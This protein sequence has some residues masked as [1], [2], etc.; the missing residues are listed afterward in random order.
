[1]T[2][3]ERA[4][5]AEP[6]VSLRDVVL[7]WGGKPMLGG[8][9]FSVE[10]GDRLAVVGPNGAGKSTLLFTMLGM[11]PPVEGVVTRRAG[12]TVGFVPQRGRHDPL[13]PVSASEV[14]AMGGMGAGAG[15]GRGRI[16]LASRARARAALA[17]LG[18]EHLAEQAFR[19]LSGGQQQRVLIARAL[20]RRP[21]LLVLDEPT[22]GMDLPS[23]RDLLE[24]VLRLAAS[25]RM[26]VVLVTHQL[27][28]AAEMA[29]RIAV[30]NKDRQVFALDTTRALMTSERLTALYG[31]AV[32]VLETASA[33]V[34]R[35]VSRER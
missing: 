12:L 20:V 25:E 30:L 32:E 29:E 4:G 35:P 7:G 28:L 1:M 18:V 3:E 16:R 33:P 14:V 31:R 22:A 26:A 23:E 27:A 10:A 19:D 21:Q 24:L 34:V 6:L 11:I 8:V 17:D 2:P 5:Q 15:K 13:F 9:T